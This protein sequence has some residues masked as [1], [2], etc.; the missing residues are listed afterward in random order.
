MSSDQNSRDA[1][2]PPVVSESNHSPSTM[3]SLS[4]EHATIQDKKIK[5]LEANID[6]LKSQISETETQLAEARRKLDAITASNPAAA[7]AI[8]K[9]HIRLLHQYN[10][11]KDIG[12]G[13][14]GLIAEARGV[15]HVDVQA[16]F[17]MGSKD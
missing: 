14:M 1:T 2:H 16:E 12:Q 6:R 13:L 8:V 17:G 7:D 9:R 10:E 11:I 4:C 15:R 3:S 5:S